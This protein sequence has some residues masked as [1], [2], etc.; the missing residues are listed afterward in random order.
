MLRFKQYLSETPLIDDFAAYDQSGHRRETDRLLTDRMVAVQRTERESGK[1]HK[2]FAHLGPYTLYHAPPATEWPQHS[3]L[4]KHGKQVV[5][6]VGFTVR[7]NTSLGGMQIA[8]HLDATEMPRFL[9]AH[10][11]NRAKIPHL[12]SQ[13]YIAAAKHFGMPV[14]SGSQQTPGGQSVWHGIAKL[15]GNVKAIN[16]DTHKEIPNYNPRKHDREVY[17][18]ENSR[19]A[20]WTLMHDPSTRR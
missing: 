11:G 13:V 14:L 19:G 20:N 10:S 5:G 1:K 18:T 6:H 8:R 9:R 15:T 12:A 17:D 16:I 4:V 3:V 2:A 7:K